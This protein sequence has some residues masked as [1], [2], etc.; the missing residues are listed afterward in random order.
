[1]P[2]GKVARALSGTGTPVKRRHA[3]KGRRDSERGDTVTPRDTSGQR[4]LRN[5]LA[6]NRWIEQGKDGPTNDETLECRRG[7]G[8]L[9]VAG[10]CVQRTQ[11][12]CGETRRRAGE[13]AIV[14]DLVSATEGP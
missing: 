13:N 3:E 14:A 6:E 7:L 4:T 8:E 11:L 2:G 9:T 10:A 5:S 12:A 1:M